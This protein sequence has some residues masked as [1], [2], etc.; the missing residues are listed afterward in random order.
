MERGE[1]F[2]YNW[3]R[4]RE[5]NAWLL[6]SLR[7]AWRINHSYCNEI[8]YRG[9]QSRLVFGFILLQ[10]RRINGKKKNL[11]SFPFLLFFWCSFLKPF[12]F[13]ET[14]QT[15]EPD[16]M[17]VSNELCL[18][19]LTIISDMIFSCYYYHDEHAFTLHYYSQIQG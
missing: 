17:S 18:F 2:T 3:S 7:I 19:Y 6:F 15:F 4:T 5:T 1:F 12:L 13:I 9:Q 11:V 10:L 8:N 16:R 14:F